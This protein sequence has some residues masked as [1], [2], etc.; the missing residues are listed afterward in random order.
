M[1][2]VGPFETRALDADDARRSPCIGIN[3]DRLGILFEPAPHLCRRA[4]VRH[5][6]AAERTG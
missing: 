6:L 1:L 2:Q 5:A 3:H 4:R